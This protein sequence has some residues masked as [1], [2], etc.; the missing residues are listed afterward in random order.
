LYRSSS[1]IQPKIG[2]EK[3]ADKACE[4]AGIKTI[5]NLSDSEAVARAYE[6]FDESYYS[7]QNVIYLALPATF[8]SDVFRAGLAEG[9]RFIIANEGPYL[10]HCAEGK[11]RAGFTSAVLEA[12]MGAGLEEIQDDYEKTYVNYYDFQDGRHVEIAP[13][14]LR[15]I[16]NI[17]TS[18]LSVCFGIE[19]LTKVDLQKAAEDYLLGIGLTEDEVARL[20]SRL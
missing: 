9:L 1:P 16:R 6:G 15:T 4:E 7:K 14:V 19:D 11:E 13:E 12:L 18:N 10:V 3:Y 8:A 5:V 2:R 17:I 20:K